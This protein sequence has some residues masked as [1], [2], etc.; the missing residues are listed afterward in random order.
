MTWKSRFSGFAVFAFLAVFLFVAVS[1][2][3]QR[4]R[5]RKSA[6]GVV[7]SERVSRNRDVRENL[8]NDEMQIH[9]LVNNERRKKGLG[10]LYWG[11]DLAELARAYSRQMARESFFSHF[12]PNGDS[13]V[14]RARN[15]DIRGWSKIGENL[16]FCEGYDDFDSLAVRGWMNSSEHRRNLLDRQYDTT[17]IGIARTRDGQIYITQ[18]FTRN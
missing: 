7:T 6:T 1:V 14:E 10:D 8:A 13:V 11:E 2:P 16:F 12:D 3:A 17:G 15:F 4:V 18:V 9:Y 5:I